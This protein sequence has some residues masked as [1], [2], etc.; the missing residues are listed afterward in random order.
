MQILSPVLSRL[1][2]FFLFLRGSV[3]TIS[4]SHPWWQL[5]LGVSFA[6][7]DLRDSVSLGLSSWPPTQGVTPT[8]P[9]WAGGEGIQFTEVPVHAWK[10]SILAGPSG[11]EPRISAELQW[12]C[13][14]GF[15]LPWKCSCVI[16]RMEN[17]LNV[18][19]ISSPGKLGTK[20]SGLFYRVR[21]TC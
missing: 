17:S 6:P 21:T 9:H 19:I 14:V 16:L 8:S 20:V 18:K 2:D 4:I 1:P 15:P 5:R 12:I 3:G 10:A 7:E 11:T 13:T